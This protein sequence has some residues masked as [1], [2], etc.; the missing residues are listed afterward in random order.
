M[1]L[2]SEPA[3]AI[4]A[5]YTMTRGA[6]RAWSAINSQLNQPRGELFWIGGPAGTG[7]THFLNY[8]V[9]LS[10]RAAASDTA[11]GR[12]LTVIADAERPGAV[13]LDRQILEQLALQLA[14]DS[15][16]SSLWRRVDGAEGLTIAFDYARRQG[17][18]GVMAAID[19]G[20]R[21]TEEIHAQLETLAAIAREFRQ[22]RLIVLAAGRADAYEGASSF[23]VAPDEDEELAVICGR[24]RHVNESAWPRVT[25][26]Y[27]NLDLGRWEPR[28]IY[29]LHPAAAKG[30]SRLISGGG[31]IA[32]GAATLREALELW[33]TAKPHDRL[34]MPAELMRSSA[35][36]RELEH[37]L[38]DAKLIDFAAARRAAAGLPE[39]MQAA[40]RA[41]V[42]TLALHYLSETAGVALADLL[43]QL[44]PYAMIT[45]GEAERLAA[46]LD[47]R[48]HGIIRWEA[49]RLYFNPEG[50]GTSEIMAF[51]QS[52]S[53][54]RRFDSSLTAATETGE[55]KLKAQRLEEALAGALQRSQQ[56]RDLLATALK[57]GN[58]GLSGQQ[59]RTFD[60]YGELAESGADVLIGIA[61][62]AARS[63]EAF[64][65]VA[66]YEALAAVALAAP[67]LRAM[68]EYLEGTGLV[69]GF[70]GDSK[71]DRA[72]AG[73]DTEC[74]LLKA[75]VAPAALI[76]GARNFDALEARFH[77]FKWNYCQAYREAHAAW[78][79]ETKQLSGLAGEA[80]SHLEALLRLNR[81]A[82][83]GEPIGQDL[84]SRMEVAG[85]KIQACDPDA[86]MVLEVQPR[87]QQCDFV[88]GAITPRAELQEL[89]ELTRRG[90]NAKLARLSQSAIA[91]LIEENNHNGKLEGFLK[92]TQAAQTDALVRVLDDKLA[93]YLT[94]LLNEKYA[95]SV[96]HG[97]GSRVANTGSA[98]NSR[99]QQLSVAKNPSGSSRS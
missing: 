82:A 95:G 92:I 25:A 9:A 11:S 46:D 29:P 87:C 78:C 83:L 28:Q 98:Q 31:R 62:D 50:S 84:S 64:K 4:V 23:L 21:E 45:V 52:L 2:V 41:L 5:C 18:K 15:R 91:R 80:R 13:E 35:A 66:D 49:S 34:L 58:E 79:Q 81:I 24:A 48:S 94:E 86:P 71:A 63:G 7:K 26:L 93:A 17:V 33:D 19:S 60:A 32:S 1:A 47:A 88:I 39:T 3:V 14:G 77:Q 89:L 20:E 40:A 97:S 75:A 65:V 37:H 57:E 27:R 69:F 38:G 30:L 74:Q 85:G 72:V 8:A 43:G 22:L 73:L 70:D 76:S 96:V 90:L 56:N 68:R 99:T 51:N 67:R 36:Q 55:L 42:D 53:L 10:N 16:G 6:E 61:A 44:P 54:A 12:Y 59:Q